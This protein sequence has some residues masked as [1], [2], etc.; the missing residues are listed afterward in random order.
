MSI[1]AKIKM[2]DCI[3]KY[4][5]V[6][7][8]VQNGAGQGISKGTRIRI[9]GKG[10]TR[11]SSP[12]TDSTEAPWLTVPDITGDQVQW[13]HAQARPECSRARTCPDAQAA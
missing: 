3:G 4:A 7:R 9:V 6:D 13:A 2:I 8:D 11:A 12:V 10:R 5:T 1:P